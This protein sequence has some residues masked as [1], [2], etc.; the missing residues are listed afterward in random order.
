MSLVTRSFWGELY[1]CIPSFALIL[2]LIRPSLVPLAVTA[3]IAIIAAINLFLFVEGVGTRLTTDS[4]I[5]KPEKIGPLPDASAVIL[6][7]LPNEQSIISATVRYFLETLEH[8]GHLQIVLAYNTPMRL[9]VEDDLEVLSHAHP[10]FTLMC[11]GNSRNKATNINAAI[12]A[13]TTPVIGFFDADSRPERACFVKACRWLMNGCDFVQGANEIGL[14]LSS[15]LQRVIAVEYLLKYQISY[16]GR[17]LA[18]GVTYFSGSNG[19]WRTEVARAV[20]ARDNAQ[21]EDID[22]ALRALLAGFRLIYDPDILACEEAPPTIFAWWR[23]RVRWAQGWAQLVRWHQ[24]RVLRSGHLSTVKKVVW[25]FF[26][27]GRRLLGPNAVIVGVLGLTLQFLLGEQFSGAETASFA[28]LFSIQVMATALTS[29]LCWTI[30][31]AREDNPPKKWTF[32]L[33]AFGFPLYDL[34]R[35]FT[36]LRGNVALFADPISWQSTPRRAAGGGNDR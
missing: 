1:L 21:V 16:L 36:I 33:Y 27:L 23:Q 12:D 9:P 31:R 13:I 19:Y 25:T 5:D 14:P 17:Q 26:L 29:F 32:I 24:S 4:L 3:A 20:R 35:E 2:M 8:S 22:M 30:L 6:A 34:M 28:C 10:R 18:F 7:Y 15:T 11:V